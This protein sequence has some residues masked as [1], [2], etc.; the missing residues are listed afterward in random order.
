MEKLDMHRVAAEFVPR[1]LADEQDFLTKMGTTT[2]PQTPYL[3]GRCINS[4][5]EYFEGDRCN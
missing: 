2:I 1:L 5:G 4:G 3:R